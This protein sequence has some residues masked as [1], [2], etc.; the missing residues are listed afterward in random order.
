MPALKDPRQEAFCHGVAKGLRKNEAYRQAGYK[1]D[2]GVART[3]SI[4]Q[5]PYIQKRINELI[6]AAADKAQVTIDRVVR[7]LALIGFA[8]T[9]SFVGDDGQPLALDQLTRDQAAAI[10][11]LTVIESFDSKTG[12]VSSRRYKYRLHDKRAALVDLGRHLGL[13]GPDL[14]INN[15]VVINQDHRPP[16]AEMLERIIKGIVANR[17][18]DSKGQNIDHVETKSLPPPV[19]ANVVSLDDKRALSTTEAFLD[20]SKQPMKP[21]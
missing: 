10:Q 17:V 1:G 11:D 4:S 3:S 18:N 6:A 15:A 13:F 8:N 21:P 14:N 5:R 9:Q 19:T 16:D 12:K 7:E 20:W 2:Y